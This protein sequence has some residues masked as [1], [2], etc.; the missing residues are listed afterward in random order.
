MTFDAREK[1]LAGG[2]PLR[3]YEF[4]RGLIRFRY[5]NADRAIEFE[6][7]TFDPV[8]IGDDGIR[9]TGEPNADAL[10]V[11]CPHDLPVATLFRGAPPADE[12]AV[13]IRDLHF[14][15]AEAHIAFIGSIDG[16]RF[17]SPGRADI[18]CQS[19]AASMRRP[20]LRLTYE[21]GCPL[22]LYDH[23]CRVNRDLFAVPAT[24][25]SMTGLT[26]TA[27]AFAAFADDYFPGG[28]I[29]W[30]IGSGETDRR[31]VE[32]QATDTLT[33]LGGTDG[34]AAGMSVTAYPGCPRTAVICDSRFNNILNYGG[35][36]HLPGKSPFDGDPVF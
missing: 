22:S 35:F 25:L 11:N 21:R 5:T 36:P 15:E 32:N 29:E 10:T 27:A 26:I 14:G 24:I 23:N 7:Q 34:L 12:V 13:I 3:L 28:Y 6:T 19:L 4:Q 31:G 20:G 30:S 1:S 2:Q 16:V 33:L 9:Q 8:A 17:P 18:S